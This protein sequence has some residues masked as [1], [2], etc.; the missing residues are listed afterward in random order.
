LP[1]RVLKVAAKIH[2]TED[3]LVQ[4]TTAEYLVQELGWERCTPITT[5]ISGRA[6]TFGNHLQG[7]GKI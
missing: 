6:T 2:Y 3:T 1:G 7:K 4:Q 5:S